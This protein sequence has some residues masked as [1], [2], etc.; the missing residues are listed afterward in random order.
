MAK[1]GGPIG[2]ESRKGVHPKGPKIKLR[3]A[4]GP[5]RWLFSVQLGKLVT[6][7]CIGKSRDG[8]TREANPLG[9]EI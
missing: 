4:K 2:Q 6:K 3:R 9:P 7:G 5:T 1:W 8:P